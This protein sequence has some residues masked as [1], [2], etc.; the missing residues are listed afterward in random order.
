M[1]QAWNCQICMLYY[2]LPDRE[3]DRRTDKKACRKCVGGTILEHEQLWLSPAIVSCFFS[4]CLRGC[5]FLC[6]IWEPHSIKPKRKALRIS[7]ILTHHCEGYPIS[8]DN[9]E[10]T[11]WTFKLPSTSAMWRIQLAFRTKESTSIIIGPST[12]K[13]ADDVSKWSKLP[14]RAEGQSE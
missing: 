10:N 14:L 4:W 11:E 9:E 8:S 6:V 2:S 13:K 12:V 3:T 5:V 7:E 1:F